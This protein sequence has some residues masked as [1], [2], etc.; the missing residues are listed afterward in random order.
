M[1]NGIVLN[2][3]TTKS[4]FQNP[5]VQLRQGDGNY[6]SLAV[7]VTSNGEPFDLTD[8]TITFMGTTAGG[9]KIIDA[10]SVVTNASQGEF[11]YTPTKA[12]GQDE[13]EFKNAYFKFAKSDETASGASFRVNVLD[14]VD[15]TAEEAKDYISVVDVMIGQVKTD[16]ETKLAETKQTL[17]D[18]QTQANTVQT[19]VND[20]NTNVNDLKAQNN[21]IKTSDNAWT[22]NNTFTQQINGMFATKSI[23]ETDYNDVA[24]NMYK[25]SGIGIIS[26][27]P[28]EN[29]PTDGATWYLIQTMPGGG[30]DSGYIQAYIRGITYGTGVN[31]GE[32]QG[33]TELADNSKV[34]HNTGTETV[35]GDKTFTGNNTF[36]QPIIGSLSSRRVTF[37][38]FADVAKNSVKYS[39]IWYK[40]IDDTIANSPINVDY[41]II[42]VIVGDNSGSG[43]IIFTPF[44]GSNVG[45]VYYNVFY[46]FGLKSWQQFADDETV[47][48]NTGTET[49]AGDKTF[50][51]NNSFTQNIQG[52]ITGNSGTTTKLQT[53][54]KINGTNF[55]GTDDINVNAANDSNLVHLAGNETIDGDKTFTGNVSV[56]GSLDAKQKIYNR[57][58]NP[59]AGLSIIYKRVG[60]IVS[61]RFKADSSGD[62]QLSS[63]DGYKSPSEYPVNVIV[64]S[65]TDAWF[66][67]DNKFHTNAISQGNFIFITDDP[68]PTN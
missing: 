64:G 46:G 25:Y 3:D 28:L 51:G 33:W 60:N 12:W 9:F 24:K 15:L 43:K 62:F 44:S 37:T 59:V 49:V 23:D 53:P 54:R 13:G 26:G 39:G 48:H 7:T 2:I 47:V 36:T 27:T 6:Q 16:M 56:T 8:W 29:S 38:D 50:T 30:P 11:T 58:I 22:G 31:Q 55:D 65:G 20:L 17:T 1:A 63:N 66:T 57:T 18:T 68:F 42:E 21:N 4:E 32:I 40:S 61:G 19:N 67:Q 34:V 52:N 41:A 10:A 35:A 14:A 5:M 45:K